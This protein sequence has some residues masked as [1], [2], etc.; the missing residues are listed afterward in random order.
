M[1]ESQSHLRKQILYERKGL[2]SSFVDS[3][4]ELIVS[5]LIDLIARHK[6]TKIAA[7]N[8]FANEPKLIKLFEYCLATKL[9]IYLPQ[10]NGDSKLLTFGQYNV[11]KQQLNKFGILQPRQ[12]S[13][14]IRDLDVIIVPLVAFDQNCNRIGMGGG[15]YD[16]TLAQLKHTNILVLGVAFAMQKVP[17]IKTNSW[18]ITLDKIVTEQEDYSNE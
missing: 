6:Y 9:Q 1:I 16:T 18:D 14:D 5:K 4:S 8:S 12:P 10:V 17:N 15:Y 2:A 7:Y 11:G 3:A 13:I